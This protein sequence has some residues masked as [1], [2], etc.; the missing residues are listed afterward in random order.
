IT[1][2]I[3]NHSV[4]ADVVF[5]RFHGRSYCIRSGA[6]TIG[7]S[8]S[9]L[10]HFGQRSLSRA[11]SLPTTPCHRHALHQQARS[12]WLL[13]LSAT[14]APISGCRLLEYKALSHL[15]AGN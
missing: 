9:T 13:R 3:G 4:L 11:I 7:Y 1:A 10:S 15:L 14:V 8:T 12:R 6:V 5:D 2:R